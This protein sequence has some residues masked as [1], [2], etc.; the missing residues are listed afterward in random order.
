LYIA[1]KINQ[2]SS[3]A[4]IEI[5]SGD[6]KY[7]FS[8]SKVLSDDFF[9][10]LLQIIINIKRGEKNDIHLKAGMEAEGWLWLVFLHYPH[11]LIKLEI[12]RDID[13]HQYDDPLEEPPMP[14]PVFATM[15]DPHWFANQIVDAIKKYKPEDFY[16]F[17]YPQDEMDELKK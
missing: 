17:A 14:V 9:Q 4:D 12:Y 6:N 15:I 8:V 2:L 16:C 3:W 10:R 1:F 11:N 13:W 7:V 5:G